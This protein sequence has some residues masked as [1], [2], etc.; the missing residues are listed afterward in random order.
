MYVGQTS[1]SLLNHFGHHRS[2][3]KKERKSTWPIYCHFSSRGRSFETHTRIPPLEH[4]PSLTS[5]YLMR[6]IGS[7]HLTQSPTLSTLRPL[8]HIFSTHIFAHTYMTVTTHFTQ[9]Y[10]CHPL[11]VF[12]RNCSG[13][14][15]MFYLC[16]ILSRLLKL[17]TFFATTATTL[18]VFLTLYYLSISLLLLF[19]C[20]SIWHCLHLGVWYCP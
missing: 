6:Y 11:L 14:I 18:L 2:A 17:S 9:L 13:T 15:S 7:G 12:A 8:M 5:S 10:H 3:A 19:F 1:K 20:W 4:C 16:G